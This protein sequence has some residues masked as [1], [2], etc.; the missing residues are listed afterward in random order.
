MS[1]FSDSTTVSICQQSSLSLLK[2]GPCQSCDSTK[3]K[4]LSYH[5]LPSTVFRQTANTYL[6]R[7]SVPPSSYCLYLTEIF[8]QENLLWCKNNEIFVKWNKRWG[9]WMDDL[10]DLYSTASS[11]SQKLIHLKE[12][13]KRAFF[14][15]RHDSILLERAKRLFGC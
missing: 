9:T 12:R 7:L 15:C 4:A 13:C 11:D 1:T 8:T 3:L 10:E 2:S 5:A 14:P 6:F